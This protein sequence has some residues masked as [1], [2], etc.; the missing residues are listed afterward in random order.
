MLGARPAAPAPAGP[1]RPLPQ[2]AHSPAT[3]SPARRGGAAAPRRPG[4]A[5]PGRSPWP[6]CLGAAH[7]AP[8]P[9]QLCRPRPG[10][11]G[12]PHSSP[13]AGHP[14]WSTRLRA[15]TRPS[16]WVCCWVHL[17]GSEATLPSGISHSRE[18]PPPN[19]HPVCQETA[20]GLEDSFLQPATLGSNP[21]VV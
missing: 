16:T 9:P 2:P 14:G 17:P 19:V 12:A 8:S 13:G 1:F 11:P 18:N 4:N 20:I 15:P 21:Q 7:L 6:P 10:L 5:R 3:C